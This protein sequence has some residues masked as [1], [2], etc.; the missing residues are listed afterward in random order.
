MRNRKTKRKLITCQC[1]QLTRQQFNSREKT[2]PK[3]KIQQ[4]NYREIRRIQKIQRNTKVLKVR[5]E[6]QMSI[7][8]ILGL[9]SKSY[10]KHVASTL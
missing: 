9:W 3:R 10:T 7:R 4:R 5:Y 1:N 6:S 8:H 2:K